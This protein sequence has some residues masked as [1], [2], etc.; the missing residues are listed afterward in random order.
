MTVLFADVVGSTALGGEHDPEIVR[1]MLGR[2]FERMSGI[3]ET[4]GGT[5]EKFIGDAM[6]VVFGVP[7]VHEDDAERSIR[8]ALAMR[9][10]LAEL[11]REL[12]FPL[13][14]RVG[15]NT[16]EAV[17]SSSG[18]Q[19][20]VTGDCV[21]VAA[22]LQQ[23][24]EPGEIVVGARTRESAHLAIEL[25]PRAAIE[26]KGKVEP[27]EAYRAIRARS[28]VPAQTRGLGPER[29]A[30]VGREAELRQVLDAFRRVVAERRV[31][32]LT[33]LGAAGVGKSR[34]VAEALARIAET[35]EVRVLRGRCLPYGT[36]I[37]YWPLI[38]IIRADAGITG[39]DLPDRAREAL[40]RRTGELLADPTEAVSVAAR[41][42]VLLGLDEPAR[43]TPDVAPDRIGAELAWATRRLFEAIADR[44]PCVVIV[45]DL[46]WTEPA[47]IEA[48]EGIA[49]GARGAILLLCV[50]RREL[51]ETTSG[52]MVGRA[53]ARL[54][55]VE[56]LSRDETEDLLGQIV[57]GILPEP[58]RTRILSRAEG[59][60]LFVEEFVRVLAERGHLVE[61]DGAWHTTGADPALTSY[62]PDSVNAVLA[63][64]LDALAPHERVVLQRAAVIGERFGLSELAAL[65]GAPGLG[66]APEGLLRKGLLVEERG[67]GG[68]RELRFKHLL[69]RDV[70]YA[71][72][73]KADRLTLHDA[74]GAALER[75]RAGRIAEVAEILA[76]HGDLALGYALELRLEDVAIAP[77]RTT[78]LRHHRLAAA[79]ALAV[80]ALDSALKHYEAALRL[81]EAI[82][83]DRDLLAELYTGLGRAHEL[84]G[85]YSES[86][87]TYE[88]M[89]AEAGRRG[90]ASFGALAMALQ[91]TIYATPTAR[92]DAP[93]AEGL[94]ARGLGL[95]RSAGD[96]SLVGRLQA[97]S[98]QLA[99]WMGRPEDGLTASEEALA[100]AHELGALDQQGFALNTIGRIHRDL[101]HPDLAT[102]AVTAAVER[103]RQI[104]DTAL[105][106]DSLST[107]STIETYRGR[108]GAALA[109]ARE[110]RDLCDRINNDW[111][112]AF[113]GQGSS[114]ALAEIGDLGGAISVWQESIRAAEAAGFVGM[115]VGPRADLGLL[116]AHVGAHD[117]AAQ[118]IDQAVTI[119]G[120]RLRP[121]RYWAL[122]QRGRL[123][124]LE[125]RLDHAA[126]LLGE[127]RG[128]LGTR[129]SELFGPYHVT[130]GAIELA[131]AQGD[132][133]TAEAG[134]AA[135]A[136][137]QRAKGMALFNADLDFLQAEAQR[138]AGRLEDA[139]GTLEQ[140]RVAAAEIG[141]RRV[142]WR[143]LASLA[144]IRSAR[145][146]ADAAA[147][148][149]TAAAGIVGDVA[150]SLEP[151]G[152]DRGFRSLPA[153]RDLVAVP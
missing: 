147:R 17:S 109:T 85:G 108:F 101:G 98:A 76:H 111:G 35:G 117:L 120:L 52:W 3:A 84:R 67:A 18:D 148:A 110:A 79:R 116:Y 30:L 126:E 19:F 142:L 39:A 23:H 89:E 145:G 58:L 92:H 119:A 128:L 55:S 99:I 93:R 107:L 69:L 6:M 11:N 94:I 4:H 9:D 28:E 131:H 103:F 72:L 59:N 143:I 133:A 87:R 88:E 1:A 64:R 151:L 95:A 135:A 2:Y 124:I 132:F 51:L 44:M 77:L 150:R 26:A 24:A 65:V 141:C 106:A 130:L 41:L 68:T 137:S 34:L 73:P 56:P 121:W 78:A 8:A 43:A 105:V 71:S 83:A 60:P 112:R 53:N 22:R 54:V 86:L 48:L 49:D 66:F 13:V 20:L 27:L 62:V 32:V 100:V 25:E 153:V 46:Q 74:Y 29:S 129:R 90:D 63:A 125:G 91:A 123:A 102:E 45:D 115:Q 80:Y 136:R 97:T 7:R 47:V 81:A 38:E 14:V 139:L 12:P 152:L 21:N 140:A 113:A 50:S 82:G 138:L 70:A 127:A 118:E 149:R 114:Y 96:R 61:R 42:A 15:I 33:L 10:A 40:E 134:A 75:E 5:V 16:G 144:A 36:G 37:T 104:G 146:E 122:A 31:E 57:G